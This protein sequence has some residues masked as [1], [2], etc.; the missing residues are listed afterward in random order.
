MYTSTTFTL[1]APAPYSN[2]EFEGIFQHDAFFVGANVRKGVQA[3]YADYIPVFLGETQRL[4]REGYVACNVAMIQVCPPDEHGYVSLGTSVDA[5]L[6]AIEIA[7]HVVAVINP[8]V[9]RAFGQAMISN[10]HD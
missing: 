2:A 5:T 3:G 6:A 8:N 9:P 4:Y 1:K 10:E 7:E